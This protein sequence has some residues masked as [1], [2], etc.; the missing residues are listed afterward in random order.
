MIYHLIKIQKFDLQ[1]HFYPA[2]TLGFWEAPIKRKNF[3]LCW[4]RADFGR[5][6]VTFQKKNPKNLRQNLFQNQKEKEAFLFFNPS[7]Q[8]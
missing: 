5:K 6:K 1:S 8:I 3:G 7:V 2:G 4:E